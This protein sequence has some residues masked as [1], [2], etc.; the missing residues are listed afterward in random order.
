MRGDFG[1]RFGVEDSNR[2]VGSLTYDLMPASQP[3]VESRERGVAECHFVTELTS[4]PGST[5]SGTT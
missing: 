2:C 4:S 1:T 3:L 5:P